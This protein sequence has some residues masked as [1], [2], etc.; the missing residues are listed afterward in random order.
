MVEAFEGAGLNVP[1][2]IGNGTY[3]PNTTAGYYNHSFADNNFTDEMC[4]LCHGELLTTQ[5]QGMDEFMHNVKGGEDVGGGQNCTQCHKM[6]GPANEKVNVTAMNLSAPYAYGVH[7][8][9]NTTADPG[10]DDSEP[11]WACHGNGSKPPKNKHN[12][13][14][15]SSRFKNPWDCED[16]HATTAAEGNYTAIAVKEHNRPSAMNA[17]ITVPQILMP[18]ME[19][20]T[21]T[22]N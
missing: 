16:C 8:K 12:F 6:R 17:I 21:Q 13:D 4:F 19:L 22:R 10:Y 11:C 7:G 18:R 15:D 14:D 9:I 5:E 2:E 3:S 1:P 20:A